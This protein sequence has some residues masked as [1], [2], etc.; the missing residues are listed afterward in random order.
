M[1]VVYS[2]PVQSL[3]WAHGATVVLGVGSNRWGWNREARKPRGF[4]CFCPRGSGPASVW[5]TAGVAQA[6][7]CRLEHFG[8]NAR[9]R[10]A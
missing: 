5:W 2:F 1:A 8:Y 7:S 10:K 3:S 6:V 4:A 9:G